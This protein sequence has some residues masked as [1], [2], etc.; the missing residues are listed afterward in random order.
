MSA[1][2]APCPSHD[3]GGTT[4]AA[5]EK[6][7]GTDTGPETGPENYK[8]QR[9]IILLLLAE[10]VRE[11]SELEKHLSTNEP[12]LVNQGIEELASIGV[13]KVYDET[14]LPSLALQRVEELELIGV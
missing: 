11:R 10:G 6:T 3:T 1:K 9:A 8:I 2:R 4:G 5:A 13:I 12:I 7:D 14:I